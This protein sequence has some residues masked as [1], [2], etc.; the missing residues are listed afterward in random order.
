LNKI[1]TIGPS[2]PLLS[3]IGAYQF[4]H[5]ANEMIR[6][7]YMK[8]KG[9]AFKVAFFDRWMVV[10]S[11]HLIEEIGRLPDDQVSFQR[12]AQ[13]LLQSKWT[14]GRETTEDPYHIEVIKE[15][16]TRNLATVLPQVMDEIQHAFDDQIPTKGDEWTEI[17]ALPVMTK[18]VARVVNRAFV[19]VPFCRDPTY[20]RLASGMIGDVYKGRT[21]LN[22]V[23]FF[24]RPIVA[25]FWL[26]T[27]LT[28]QMMSDIMMPVIEERQRKLRELGDD[29]TDKPADV[30][31][32]ILEE[33]EGKD[34]RLRTLIQML[35]V[36]N[37]VALHSSSGGITHALYHLAAQP[38]YIEPLREEI[39]LTI[40][41]EG[42]TKTA[43]NKMWKLDSF[44]KESQRIN[45]H[46]CTS[47]TRVTLKDVYFSDG[48]LV[49]AGTLLVAAT[50]ATQSDDN[51]YPNAAE[52]DAFRFSKLR[53]ENDSIKYQYATTSPEFIT[54]G[55]GKHAC[56]GR[57][58]AVDELK[59]IMA[60]IV[61]NYDVKFEREGVRPANKWISTSVNPDPTAK[62][63]FR[64]RK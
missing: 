28:N 42:W 4:L 13:E 44:M 9:R 55:H 51:L 62:V 37:F 29:W 3:Y 56:P 43:L 53:E 35:L 38:E 11:G 21:L 57:F 27:N 20:L 50:L 17:H 30:L 49:P 2:A 6:E 52:F 1:P 58:F 26:P 60:Y 63:L 23:P 22:L 36:I 24:L 54:F 15:K 45:G 59:S 16:L 39:E 18:I 64:R 46:N 47:L 5:N 8:Y 31:M 32:W 34:S 12:G 14:L 10:V 33:A 19:G 25:H 7:G 61:L 40:A 48:T 41:A